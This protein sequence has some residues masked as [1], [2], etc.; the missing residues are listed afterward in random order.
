MGSRT[1]GAALT[2][3][4]PVFR[5]ENS[6]GTTIFVVVHDQGI[7]NV[8]VEGAAGTALLT[9]Q[10]MQGLLWWFVNKPVNH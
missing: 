10:E 9:E 7:Y 5:V 8:C 3:T 6:Q 4:G 1:S 2:K